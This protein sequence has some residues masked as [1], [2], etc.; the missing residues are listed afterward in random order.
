M[1]HYDELTDRLHGPLLA[2]GAAGYDEEL[3]GFQTGEPHRPDVVVGAQDAADVA[4][5]VAFAAAHDVPVAVHATGHG[6]G[7]GLEGGVVISTRGM[8]GVRIYPDTAVAHIAAGARWAHVAEAAAEHG[9]APL[10]GSFP[11]VGAV[12]YLLG[13]GLGLMGRRYGWAADHVRAIELVTADGVARRA[14]ADTEPELFWA[15]RGGREP[16]AVVTAVEVAL[17]AVPRIVGGGLFFAATDAPQ[18][19][20]AVRAIGAEAPDE[21]SVSVGAIDI[22][23]LPAVPEPLRG[24]HVLHVRLVDATPQGAAATDAAARLGGA[25]EVLLGG[26]RPMPYPETGSIFAEPEA[27]HAYRGTNV[28]VGDLDD[29]MLTD[30]VAAAG[31]ADVPCVVDVRRL[32][33]ALGHAPE[34]P[35]AVSFRDAAWIVRVLSATEGHTPAAVDAQHDA[36]LR[37]L[38]PVRRGR[39]AGF[40]YGPVPAAPDELHEPEILSRLRRTRERV[41]PDGRFAATSRI[42]T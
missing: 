41:D 35:D 15:L 18:V 23:D 33:G 16:L 36:V 39:S 5:A 10:S 7:A 8:Q 40:L 11:G 19:L 32:G 31:T 27:P 28:L 3:A 14:T 9:L 12:G 30:V 26:I 42:A 1:P 21:L 17:F 34:V 24:R 38:D 20:P 4:A 22:P 25:G 6:R 2:R 13:G 29:T 37:P